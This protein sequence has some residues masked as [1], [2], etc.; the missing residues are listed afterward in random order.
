M[1]FGTSNAAIT[2]EGWKDFFAD[3]AKKVGEKNNLD[4]WF[5]DLPEVKDKH[6]KLQPLK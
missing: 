5:F 1:P 6:F 3:Q 4:I 2:P